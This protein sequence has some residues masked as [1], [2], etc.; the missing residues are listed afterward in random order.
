MTVLGSPVLF[1]A[2]PYST[3]LK[4][5]SHRIRIK[6]QKCVGSM[7]DMHNL[8]SLSAFLTPMAQY[9]FLL[10]YLSKHGS[11]MLLLLILTNRYAHSI[12]GLLRSWWNPFPLIPLSSW[13]S[14]CLLNFQSI[15]GLSDSEKPELLFPGGEGL[16]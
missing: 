14:A 12:L 7:N 2:F 11:F 4:M 6:V 10:L 8:N 3:P 15:S 13:S 1:F 16:A 9:L 5:K